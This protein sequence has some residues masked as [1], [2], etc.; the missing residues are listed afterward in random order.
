MQN[1]VWLAFIKQGE[2]CRE[3][4]ET[5]RFAMFLLSTISQVYTGNWSLIRVT[6]Q[7]C[8]V[9]MMSHNVHLFPYCAVQS[10]AK[11]KERDSML[12]VFWLPEVSCS[13][14]MLSVFC[15]SVSRCCYEI[16]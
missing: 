9:G 2:E 13:S 15:S 11:T 16:S 4:K 12:R 5:V 10:I 8:K 7:S 6:S 1:A 3:S 14:Y